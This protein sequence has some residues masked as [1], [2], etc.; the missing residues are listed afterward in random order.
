VSFEGDS[1][2]PKRVVKNKQLELTSQVLLDVK[3]DTPSYYV[4]YV[5]ISHTPYD[6]T[7]SVCKLP[8]PLSPEQIETAKSGKP[9]S[10]EPIVQIVLPPLLIDGLIKALIDQKEKYE[11]TLAQQVKNNASEHQHIKIPSRIQ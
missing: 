2:M 4:N 11:K 10:L 5:G 6:F 3:S 9:L 1:E 8:S 7:L